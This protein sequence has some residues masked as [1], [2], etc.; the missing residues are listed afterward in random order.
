MNKE[1]QTNKE[2]N[3]TEELEFQ[4][5]K[6][7]GENTNLKRQLIKLTNELRITK[8]INKVLMDSVN[9]LTNSEGK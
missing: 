1:I 2:N 6:H 5:S 9:V 3:L 7:I 8:N 4:I